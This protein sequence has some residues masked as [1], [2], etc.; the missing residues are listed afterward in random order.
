MHKKRRIVQVNTVPGS[1]P[2]PSSKVCIH[3]FVRDG[4]GPITESHALHP[5]F[6]E[7]G[8]QVKQKVTVGPARGRL[9]CDPRRTAAPVNRGGV[10]VVTPRTEE[11]Q[12]VTCPKC[13]SSPEYIAA[14]TPVITT[15]EEE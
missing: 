11:P 2:K 7:S 10:T 9:A 6:D 14:T 15:P 8:V 13:M 1:P 12:A 5:V 3:F 4:M